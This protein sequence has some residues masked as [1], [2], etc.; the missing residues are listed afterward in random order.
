MNFLPYSVTDVRAMAGRGRPDSP[1]RGVW[2]F[3]AKSPRKN[4]LVEKA[5][6]NL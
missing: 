4:S 5:Y 3:R 2:G 1:A 6:G